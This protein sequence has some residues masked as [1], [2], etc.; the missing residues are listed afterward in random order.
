MAFTAIVACLSVSSCKDFPHD[1]T[2]GLFVTVDRSAC[3]GVPVDSLMV[4]V[5]T[6]DGRLVT[7][8]RYSGGERYSPILY[9]VGGGCYTVVA[10]ANWAEG[11]A[12]RPGMSRPALMQWLT[13]SGGEAEAVP[14]SGRAEACVADGCVGDVTVRLGRDV[15]PLPVMRLTATL[16]GAVMPPYGGAARSAGRAVARRFVVEAL[17]K[18]TGERVVRLDTVAYAAPGSTVAF[19]V[20]LDEG[21][22]DLRLWSDC[23]GPAAGLP[24]YY[25]ASDL[26]QVAMS[27]APYAAGA[28]GRDAAYATAGSVSVTAGGASVALDMERPLAR[29]RLIATDVGKYED[30]DGVPPLS[31]LTVKVEYEGFFPSSFN[32]A[33]G[34]PN[35]AV[36]GLS[37]TCRPSA[38]GGADG[39]PTLASDWILA[40]DADNEISLTVSLLDAEGR[41]VS[42][43]RRVRV[44]Y[45]GGHTTTIRGSFLT[46]G[47][48]SGGVGLDHGWGD[49]TFIVGF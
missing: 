6:R 46:A 20:P 11:D 47:S 17:F 3:Q 43:T 30:M 39:G 32:V 8:R 2:R 49:D 14:L 38:G 24:P 7:E 44:P 42:R 28:D 12:P 34:R 21:S 25:D 23:S 48:G 5:Y 13:R 41:T 1:G 31:D 45:R 4:G 18:G 10:V 9:I 15:D 22:Y 35:D 36:E 33:T 29:Y 40:A 16:P 26:R 37:Y 19:A 27:T